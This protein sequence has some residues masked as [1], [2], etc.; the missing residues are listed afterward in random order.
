MAMAGEGTIEID[1]EEIYEFLGKRELKL[2]YEQGHLVVIG[3]PRFNRET[4]QLEIDYAFDS[5]IPPSDWSVRPKAIK[6]WEEN[7][8]S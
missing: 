4:R 7:S 6:Q 3:V 2:H 5:S 8:G 1:I